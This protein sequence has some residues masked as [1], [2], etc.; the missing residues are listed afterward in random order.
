[1]NCCFSA[2]VSAWA[3][4]R[5]NTS[6]PPPGDDQA[7]LTLAELSQASGQ[8][9]RAVERIETVFAESVTLDSS[10]AEADLPNAPSPTRDVPAAPAGAGE[11]R[12]A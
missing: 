12:R 3:S 6:V 7:A 2:S 10:N 4:N 1:M 5:A 9:D 8:V 11:N